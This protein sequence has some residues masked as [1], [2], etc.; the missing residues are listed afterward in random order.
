MHLLQ[1]KHSITLLVILSLT[2]YITQVTASN[3]G[4]QANNAL[5]PSN[6]CCSQY[7]WCGSGEP[8]CGTGCQSGPCYGSS[9]PTISPRP[10]KAPNT[11]APY[12]ATTCEIYRNTVNFG[13]YEEW[14]EYRGSNCNNLA[15]NEINVNAFGYTHLAFSFAGI[16]ST[17]V[18]E[19]YNGNTAYY[20]K[21]TQFNSLKNTNPNLKTLIAVGGWNFD[22]TRFSN[23]AS[24]SAKRTTFANSVVTFLDTHNFDGID[25]DW[26]YPVTRQGTPQDYAN[27][28][29]LCQALRTAFDNAGHSSSDPEPWL[30][31]IATS[32]NI[33]KIE[34][35]YDMISMSNYVDWFNIMS[36]D[37]YGSWDSTAGAN[38]VMRYIESTFQYIFGLGVKREQ[39]VLG[40]A[41]Y[42]R[43]SKLA[44]P[45]CTTIGCSIY[46]AG[47]SGC[48]GE[49]GNLPWFQIKEQYVDVGPSAYDSLTFNPTTGSMEL[50]TG[51]NLYFT[52]FDNEDT[53]NIKYQYAWSQ[54]L[55]G[56]MW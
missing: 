42:G 48:H 40:L 23:V 5:C 20:T 6:Y 10:T 8:W 22:Q 29:L 51:G 32:I 13:Y 53:F 26:E 28:P 19:P 3:C 21:Y 44:D 33:E 17:G 50:V 30:I 9:A 14:A 39:L 36:Y 56:I 1:H 24:T 35:G 43:S 16:S 31:T 46:G 7:G 38:T 54:C 25:I 15:P 27:Y 34:R 41:A 12:S 11:A 49:A 45:T 37:I 2:T 52:S 18:I 47:L 55:R 4:I